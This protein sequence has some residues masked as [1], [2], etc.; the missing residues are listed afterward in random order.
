MP[1]IAR[2]VLDD[3]ERHPDLSSSQKQALLAQVPSQQWASPEGWFNELSV[4]CANRAEIRQEPR[5]MNRLAIYALSPL[6]RCLYR[7]P[8]GRGLA[9]LKSGG[10]VEAYGRCEREHCERAKPM[11]QMEGGA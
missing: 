11:Q 7:S 4:H 10:E 1:T 9:W 3:I 2:E 8:D 5:F 6:P